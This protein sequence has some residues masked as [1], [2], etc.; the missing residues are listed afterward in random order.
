MPLRYFLGDCRRLPFIHM[1]L[2][3]CTTVIFLWTKCGYEGPV[4]LDFMVIRAP[5]S[6]SPS[7]PNGG[8]FFSTHIHTPDMYL[9]NSLQTFTHGQRHARM[10][11]AVICSFVSH[12]PTELYSTSDDLFSRSHY[13]LR[14]NDSQSLV[15]QL[16]ARTI[17]NQEV[18]GPIPAC[19][20]VFL[21][22][23]FM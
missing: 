17:W 3:V 11:K 20:I 14:Q 6:D 8:Y 9:W 12:Y 2:S 15:A 10:N 23:L 21:G 5:L 7:P 18:A 19:K 4:R 1:G 22:F 16:A 13:R